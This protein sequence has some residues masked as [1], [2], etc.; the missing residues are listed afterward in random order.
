MTTIYMHDVIWVSSGNRCPPKGWRVGHKD[1]NTLNNQRNNL[2]LTRSNL[3]PNSVLAA[4]DVPT[5]SEMAVL[6]RDAG[7]PV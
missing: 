6:L 1:G 7:Y 3:K 4:T 5:Q 2:F